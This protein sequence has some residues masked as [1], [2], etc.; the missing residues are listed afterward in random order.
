MHLRYLF[1]ILAACTILFCCQKTEEGFLSDK[2]AYRP[3]PFIAGQGIVSVSKPLDGDG[4]TMPLYVKLL[5][6]RS[7]KTGLPLDSEQ[8]KSREALGYLAAVSITD[9]SLEMLNKKI[10]KTMVRP[11]E[12]NNIGGRIELSAT[13]VALDTG[14][15]TIDIEVS[16]VRGKK[17]IKDACTVRLLPKIYYEI[18]STA[19]TTSTAGAETDFQAIP[20]GLGITIDRIADGPNKIIIRFLDKNG[21]PF[22]PAVGDVIKRGDRPDFATYDPYYPQEKTDT[23]LVFQ[24]PS[25]PQFPVYKVPGFEYLSYYR[26]PYTKNSTGR[27]VN[28]TFSV[29]LNDTGTWIYTLRIPTVAKL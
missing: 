27:N 8:L 2:L 18:K 13:S 22:N 19:L 9:T 21:V 25:T 14:N 15:Y 11:F 7:L 24:Y 16:N 20:G 28:V 23:A 17:V 26:I 12:V 5:E 6:I 4:S 1:L 29:L 10:S 3:N